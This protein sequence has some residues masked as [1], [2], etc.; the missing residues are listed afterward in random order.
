[1]K[2]YLVRHIETKEIQGVFWGSLS[3]IWDCF[4][5]L[6]DPSD[7]EYAPLRPGAIYTNAPYGKGRVARPYDEETDEDVTFDWSGFVANET[8]RD[9]LHFDHERLRWKRF[10]YSSEGVGLLAR[11]FRAAK[12]KADGE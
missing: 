1:M 3:E 10:D 11:I 12:E 2:V 5:E 9:A 6:S 7:C 4:D 8:F